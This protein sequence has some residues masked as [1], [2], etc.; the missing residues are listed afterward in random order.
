MRQ[1]QEQRDAKA[2]CYRS[3]PSTFPGREESIRLEIDKPTPVF[4]LSP[5][6]PS[7]LLPQNVGPL[8]KMLVEGPMPV[9]LRAPIGASIFLP[10]QVSAFAESL[11]QPRLRFR[12]FLKVRRRAPS[13]RP[14]P[15]ASWLVQR[16]AQAGCALPLRGP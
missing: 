4:I 16:P 15:C 8:P 13:D 11:V 7:F 2:V 9:L 3:T 6:G 12:I 14:E 1:R 10:E 5:F